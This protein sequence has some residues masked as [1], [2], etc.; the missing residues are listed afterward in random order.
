VKNSFLFKDIPSVIGGKA[1]T[2][3][4]YPPGF[5]LRKQRLALGLSA[6]DVASMSGI[7]LK[8]YERF[9][10]VGNALFGT[11]FQIGLRV[12]RALKLDPFDLA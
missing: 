3:C 9:E 11:S 7:T 1:F 5:V 6:E 10:T 2:V 4:V 8:Q 12:C